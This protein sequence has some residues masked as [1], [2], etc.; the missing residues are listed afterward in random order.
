MIPELE[1]T[2]MSLQ[3]C[4]QMLEMEENISIKITSVNKLAMLTVVMCQ[5]TKY[6][7]VET[8]RLSG[9]THFI[10]PRTSFLLASS[11]SLVSRGLSN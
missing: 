6:I 9:G 8:K 2:E 1:N 5:N 3:V 10:R 4:Q 11:F 7:A